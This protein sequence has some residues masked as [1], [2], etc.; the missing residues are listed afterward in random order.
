[1]DCSP[2]GSSV[3]GILQGRRL[4]WTAMLSLQEIFL[5]QG[6][7][8]CL[9]CL[10][11]WQAASLPLAPPGKPMDSGAWRTTVHGIAELDMTQRLST[12]T[13][14]CFTMLCQLLLYSKVNQLFVY[15][16]LSPFWI[17]FPLS[18]PQSFESSRL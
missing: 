10:L 16:Y 13:D 12:H 5:S 9:F 7:N 17:S 2:P 3:H 14:N 4:E 15:I 8:P 11:H 18:L 6:A 1:M